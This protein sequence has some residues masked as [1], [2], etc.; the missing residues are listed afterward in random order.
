MG[1]GVWAKVHAKEIEAAIPNSN[2]I[3]KYSK[4]S[5]YSSPWR[6]EGLDLFWMSRNESK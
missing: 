4:A 1:K 3:N 2:G 6:E 5:G